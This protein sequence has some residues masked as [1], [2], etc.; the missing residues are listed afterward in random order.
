MSE[1]DRWRIPATAAVTAVLLM[2]MRVTRMMMVRQ[3]QGVA[4]VSDG[5]GVTELRVAIIHS[6]CDS[7]SS[8]LP[9]V[10]VM[11]GSRF[12]SFRS[13]F[14]FRFWVWFGLR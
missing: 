8:E 11:S 12:G 14:G 9:T 4:R 6:Q 1:R 2:M 7:G 5:G 3:R 13:S 10:V